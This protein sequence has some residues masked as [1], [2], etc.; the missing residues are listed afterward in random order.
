MID[1]RTNHEMNSVVPTTEI[2]VESER[3]VVVALDRSSISVAA[4]VRVVAVT[5]VLLFIGGFLANII[6]SLAYLFFL[7]VLSVFFAYLI[8]P[9]VKLIRRPFK[10]RKIDRFMPR[11]V[12]ILIAY[13]IV[14]SVLGFGIWAVAPLVSE[15]GREFGASLPAY[16]ANVRQAVN[17]LDRR[18]DRMR[19]SEDL[20]NRINEQASAIGTS[21]TA[22]FGTFLLG[23]AAYLP[24]LVLVP[25]LA[26][27]FLKDVNLIRLAVL[28]LF[29]VGP[30]RMRAGWILEDINSTLAAYTRAQLLSCLLIGT[31]CT[32]GFYLIGLKYALLLGI[33]AGVFEF[34]PL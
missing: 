25:I 28:R 14:F 15:Q 31:I 26:F 12:A 3:P 16:A 19:L 7:L 2:K 20:Q 9:L 8:D 27:F 24:W 22:A 1:D 34:V 6:T 29:P 23:F 17:D 18:F 30:L 11:S 5:L 4:I 13:V 32:A 21:I 10:A 33:L